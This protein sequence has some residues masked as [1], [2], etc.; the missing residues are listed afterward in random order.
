MSA[1][2]TVDVRDELSPDEFLHKYALPRRPVALRGVMRDWE[3]ARLWSF[4]FFRAR[5]GHLRVTARRSDDYEDTRTLPL[6]DYLD[7]LESHSAE[8]YLKDWEFEKD[9]PE[10]RAHYQLPSYFL[11]WTRHL[12]DLIRPRWRW[13]FIG[14]P[15]T[16]SNLH[17]DFLIT[18]AWNALFRGTKRWHFYSPE[19]A[20]LMYRGAVNAFE[21]DLERFPRFSLARPLIHTQTAG[22]VMFT[23]SGWWHAVRNEDVTLALSENFVNGTNC[24][25]YANVR[26]VMQF[27]RYADHPLWVK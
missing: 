15:R 1:H 7:Q 10:L 9:L 26:Q 2:G 8:Y 6:A 27:L 21:P 11:S 18:S 3:A 25:V 19:Q 24:R 20:P 22:E 14:P 4:D 16:A 12:P 17:V 23:P 5:Y 13:L